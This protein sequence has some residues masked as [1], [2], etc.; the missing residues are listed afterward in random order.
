V[1]NHVLMHQTI[2]GQESMLQMKRAGDY[3]DIIVGCTGGGSNFAGIA[4]PF[5]RDKLVHGKDIRIVAAEPAAC[6]SLT[7]GVYAYDFGD[8]AGMTPLVKMHTLGSAFIPPP[9]H[10]GGLRYHGMASI[11]SELYDQKIIEAVAVRQLEAFAAAVTFLRA[12]GIVPAP[13]ASHAIAQVIREANNA[14][15]A[16][17][18][19]VILFNLCGHGHF[20]MSAYDAYTSG[21]LTDFEYPA[22]AVAASMA[23]LPKVD[24]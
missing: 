22:E 16:G 15:A 20:D 14:T 11:I 8:T 4:F 5:V 2:I 17:T 6:P 13:E 24:L 10:S 12:E 19:P 21:Q 18:S 1:L 3:P 23:A 7:K 9:V